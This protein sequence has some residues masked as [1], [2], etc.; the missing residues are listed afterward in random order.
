MT[1][2]VY[3]KYNCSIEAV[4]LKGKTLICDSLQST[5]G[6]FTSITGSKTSSSVHIIDSSELPIL[7]YTT[8]CGTLEFFISTPTGSSNQVVMCCVNKTLTSHTITTYQTIGTLTGTT[9]TIVNGSI[10]VSPIVNTVLFWKFTG[11]GIY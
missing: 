6:D 9:I 11:S 2:I 7:A 10:Q 5:T 4:N 3:R 1:I 8:Y